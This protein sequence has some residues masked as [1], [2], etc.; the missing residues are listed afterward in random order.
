[1]EEMMGGEYGEEGW[2]R[3][4]KEKGIQGDGGKWNEERDKGWRRGAKEK[5]IEGVGGKGN[6]ERETEGGD[7]GEDR[8]RRVM[9]Q[10]NSPPLTPIRV[11]G[12]YGT[13]NTPFG[14]TEAQ[15]GRT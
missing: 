9:V 13:F 15:L 7:G 2:R 12:V 6:E 1:M 3:G 8:C 5:R 10:R 14:Q 4:A 11:C